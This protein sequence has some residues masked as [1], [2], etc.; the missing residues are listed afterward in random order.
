MKTVRFGEFWISNRKEYPKFEDN[1]P[2]VE[3]SEL[4]QLP[5]MRRVFLITEDDRYVM[6]L[7]QDAFI[8]NWRK[9]NEEDEYPH[10]N[11]AR[12]LFEQKFA[13]FKKFVE[14]NEIGELSATRY[15]VT[16]VNHL[17]VEED[18]KYVSVFDKDISLIRLQSVKERKL[19]P[20]AR[21]MNA[22]VWF[23]LPKESG[24]LRISFKQGTR[25]VDKRD[26]LQIELTARGKANPD[27][28]DMNGWLDLAHEWIVQGFTEIT[29]EQAHKDWG[30]TI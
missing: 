25:A 4:M 11:T 16:Y 19:L 23:D 28:S 29:T 1:P 22:D 30:R 5:P 12:E 9:I 8:H 10:F 2:V 20:E 18:E 21:T 7:Q 6:Q 27:F 13:S 15:E 24:T 17:L 26:V 3:F 14:V